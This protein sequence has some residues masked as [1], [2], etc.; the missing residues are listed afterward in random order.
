MSNAEYVTQIYLNALGRAPSLAELDTYIRGLSA[1]T[2]TRQQIALDISQSSEHLVVG[3]VHRATNNFDVIMNPAEFERN[4]DK[5]Y[6]RGLVQK[7]VD[8]TYDRDATA[9]ELDY[10][11]NKLLTDVSNPDDIAALLLGA[12]GD[13]QGV[14]SASLHGLSGTA[15]VQ[16]AFENAF[17]RAATAQEETTWMQNLYSGRI[18]A[19]QFIA[20]LAQSAEHLAAGNSHE[21]NS[22]PTVNVVTPASGDE[23]ESATFLT[24]TAGQDEITGGA[25]NE[26][27]TGY[28]GSDKLTGGFGDDYLLGGNGNDFYYWAKGDGN[29]TISET[30]ASLNIT[31]TLVFEDVTPGEVVLTRSGQNL[32]ITVSSTGETITDYYHFDNAE[33]RGLEMIEFSDGTIWNRADIASVTSTNGIDDPNG[34]ETVHGSVYDDNLFG[35]AGNDSLQGHQGDD[36]LTGGAGDDGLVGG[37]GSDTYVWSKGDGNDYIDDGV[38]S[39]KDIDTLKL[40]DVE[41]SDVELTRANGSIDLKIRIISTGEIITDHAL[42]WVAGDQKPTGHGLERIEF[43]DGVIWSL[44]DI[45]ANTRIEGTSGNDG[46]HGSHY[47]DVMYGLEGNDTL[48]GYRGNDTLIG[49][50]G[51]DTMKGQQGSDT[52]VWSK[53]DGNDTIYE[54]Q[55][56]PTDIDTLK[57][58]DVVSSDVRLRGVSSSNMLKIEILSTGEIITDSFFF[59]AQANGVKY[60]QGIERIE[61][62]DGLVWSVDDIIAHTMREGTDGNETLSGSHLHDVISG[63]GGNDILIGWAGDDILI[64]GAGADAMNGGAGIDTVSYRTASEGVRADLLAPGNNLGDAAGDTYGYIEN[65]EG[66]AFSDTLLGTSGRNV[67]SGGDGNDLFAGRGGDDVILGGNGNDVLWGD[68]GADLLDGGDG[69][70]MVAYTH[71]GSG[72]VVDL[73]NSGENTGEAAG[74]M[75]VSIE[76]IA[77]TNFADDLRGDEK[78]NILQ[79]KDGDDILHGRGGNDYLDGGA[80]AD[81]L[82]GGAGNDTLTGSSNWDVFV[83]ADGFGLDTITDF[84]VA[85]AYEKIDLQAV[86]SI[87]DFADLSANHM[88]QIGSDTVIH[89]NG[90]NTITLTGVDMSS[91]TADDFIF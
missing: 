11:S 86:S 68:G 9:Q 69:Q 45:F 47:A 73:V 82:Y 30:Q 5:A 70:D 4:L 23:E 90:G 2:L 52:Y 77:G 91:L 78:N 1:N 58:T 19:G 16:Q 48:I 3:N 6:V 24:G 13:I 89:A 56:S 71:S 34:G 87:T 29:D 44:E 62:A 79:G 55:N 33:G 74:D 42:F 26:W 41:S 21:I 39:L 84:D 14:S 76:R 64:G 49:G 7:I 61:F 72:V 37:E 51:D 59:R 32:V 80:G 54:D 75:F 10:L 66:S 36:V 88:S 60:H 20:S 8:V 85:N 35:F 83:F 12:D 27:L 40:T 81:V 15:F 28:G 50:L 65:L 63:L 46:L 17:G 22:L 31:D 43:S 53:G 18:S 67:I 25:A 38:I 57:L